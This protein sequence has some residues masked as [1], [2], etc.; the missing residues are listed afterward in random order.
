MINQIENGKKIVV[1]THGK[2]GATAYTKEKRWFHIP[3][4]LNYKMVNCNG[5]GDNFFSGFLY[6]YSNNKTIEECMK[7]GTIAGALCVNTNELVSETLNK[8]VLEI[9]YLDHYS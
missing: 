4:L 5:A 6:A 1:C 7:F 8:N 9:I 3:A 2:N